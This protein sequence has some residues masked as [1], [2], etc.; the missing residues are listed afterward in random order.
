[1]GASGIFRKKRHHKSFKERLNN[2]LETIFKSTL[3]LVWPTF[4][5]ALVACGWYFFLF[6]HDIHF[7]DGVNDII[8]TAWVGVFGILYSLL[9][10]M[11]LN[12]VWSEYK[13]IRTA[14]KRG[15]LDTFVDLKDEELS[16]LM[17]VLVSVV[18]IAVLGGFVFLKY[19][20]AISGGIIVYGVSFLLILLLLVVAEIDDPCAGLWFIKNIPDEWLKVDPREFRKR[21]AD[22]GEEIST[23]KLKYIT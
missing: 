2:K 23:Q 11:A 17:Y 6:K 10:T 18:S 19:P 1:M 9:A 14:V 20:D 4:F 16:P 8:A 21:R 13:S 22:K 3:L 15:D 7:N 5:A 12:T